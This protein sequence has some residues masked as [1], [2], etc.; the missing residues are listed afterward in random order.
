MESCST[1]NKAKAKAKEEGDV[2]SSE[3]WLGDGTRREENRE[4]TTH[5]RL[6]GQSHRF[7]LAGD[8]EV[9]SLARRDP[10]KTDRHGG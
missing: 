2:I 3:A 7:L 6:E 8:L 5:R 10:R 9:S 4:K 1:K